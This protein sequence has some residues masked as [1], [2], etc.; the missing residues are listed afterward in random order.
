MIQII[1]RFIAAGAAGVPA[2]FAAIGIHVLAE[3]RDFFDALISQ[4]GDLSSDI[5][6]GARDLFATGIGHD[7]EAAIFTAAFHDR[8]KG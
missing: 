1:K 3:Q 8:D 5:F 6:E 7:T 2:H 4:I